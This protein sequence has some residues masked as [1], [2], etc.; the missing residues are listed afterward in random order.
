MIK[1]TT[2]LRLHDQCPAG[3]ALP[4]SIGDGYLY[5]HNRLFAN[6][7]DVTLHLDFGY[8]A[9][10]TKVWKDYHALPLLSLQMIL[11]GGFLPYVDNVAPLR[12][13]ARQ[14]PNFTFPPGF[15]L[16]NIRKN[17]VFHESAHFISHRVL[18][19]FDNLFAGPAASTREEFVFKNLV[20]E[21]FANAS[22]LLG[23]SLVGSSEQH[24]Y[25]YL[26][27]SYM[28]CSRESGKVLR[29]AAAALGSAPTLKFICFSYL[30]ANLCYESVPPDK[31]DQVMS[32]A[33]GD[34][35]RSAEELDALGK[36]SGYAL[37]LSKEFRE[38]TAPVYFDLFGCKK[39]FDELLH[40]DFLGNPSSVTAIS[41]VYD[42]LSDYAAEGTGS[43]FLSRGTEAQRVVLQRER[44]AAR[45][46]LE[47]FG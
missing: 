10:A 33:F 21:A 5:R 14:N 30:F 20:S 1:L 40:H 38:G 24:I 27:N 8:S 35:R 7:R 9:K 2:L 41:A 4:D 18:S 15:L 47:P 32:L 12:R 39:E 25:F 34:G 3:H 16:D 36:I 17:H 45:S 6:I 29:D 23:S 13:L 28:G 43:R 42:E 11:D 46:L 31:M 22:E 19:R 44:R 37:R 26:L